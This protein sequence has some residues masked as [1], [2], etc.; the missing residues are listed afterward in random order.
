MAPAV[1]LYE[2]TRAAYARVLGAD[3]P[4]TLASCVNLA[5][6]YYAVGRVTDALALLR[7]TLARCEQDLPPGDPVT[8]SAREA[9]ASM[10]G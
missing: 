7:D 5:Y 1:Q 8:G 3:H 2:E 10:A 9:L 4:D 6:S